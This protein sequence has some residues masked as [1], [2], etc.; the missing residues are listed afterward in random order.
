MKRFPEEAGEFVASEVKKFRIEDFVDTPPP[1]P[2]AKRLPRHTQFALAGTVLALADAGLNSED[3]QH[4]IPGD[5][6]GHFAD[7]Q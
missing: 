4:L 2:P 5:R 7:G 3:V 1:P 6:D